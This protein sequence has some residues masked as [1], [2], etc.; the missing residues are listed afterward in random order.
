MTVKN[1][2][3]GARR[4]KRRRTPGLWA[5]GEWGCRPSTSK[6]ES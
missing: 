6:K 4:G 1:E 2:Y 3:L 5:E